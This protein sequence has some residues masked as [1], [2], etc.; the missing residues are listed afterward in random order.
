MEGVVMILALAVGFVLM[1]VFADAV[2]HL[3]AWLM[4]W[5]IE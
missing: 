3:V 1:L 5:D 2:V 4:G